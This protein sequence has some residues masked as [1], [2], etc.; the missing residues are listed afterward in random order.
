MALMP[1][2]TR[3]VEFELPGV[4]TLKNLADFPFRTTRSIRSKAGVEERNWNGE[5]RTK[6]VQFGSE[7]TR[8][9]DRAACLTPGGKQS[10]GC[11]R[12]ESPSADGAGRPPWLPSDCVC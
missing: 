1:P 5:L 11:S 2:E 10:G 6:R 4:V 3:C 12:D 7:N 8:S 9:P